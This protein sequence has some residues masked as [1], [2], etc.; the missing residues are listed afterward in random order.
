MCGTGQNQQL[1]PLVPASQL[2]AEFGCGRTDDL[3]NDDLKSVS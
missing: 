3:S 1:G 2:S